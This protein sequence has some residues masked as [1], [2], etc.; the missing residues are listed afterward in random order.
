MI[1]LAIFHELKL[2]LCSFSIL[3][4]CIVAAL[5]LSALKSNYL[6]ILLFL[7]CHDSH[8][9]RGDPQYPQLCTPE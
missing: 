2:F 3:L 1:P 7:G 6:C 5:A 9:F 4:G 8:S